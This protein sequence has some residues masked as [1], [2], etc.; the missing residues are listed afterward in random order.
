MKTSILAED[1][2]RDKPCVHV[3]AG[4]NV[5]F[6]ALLGACGAFRCE[7]C[8]ECWLASAAAP[9]PLGG[10][11]EL[12]TPVECPAC[13][14]KHL[15]AA[16]LCSPSALSDEINQRIETA[17]DEAKRAERARLG[18]IVGAVLQ[19]A[20]AEPTDENLDARK[21]FAGLLQALQQEDDE[22]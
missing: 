9:G 16:G 20:R 1:T 11:I 3:L 21:M 2:W 10:L 7:T 5:S 17:I 6:D 4:G 15:D 8:R 18:L 19:G 12:P 13:G 22:G 14:A